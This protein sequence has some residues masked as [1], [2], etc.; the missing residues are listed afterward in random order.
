MDA[1]DDEERRLLW[2][3]LERLPGDYRQ[4]IQLRYQEGRTFEEI[5]PLMGR[6]ANAARLLWLRAVECVKHEFGQ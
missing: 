2:Q 1:A 5:G 3:A 6:S 4:V